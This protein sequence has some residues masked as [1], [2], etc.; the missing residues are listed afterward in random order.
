M[1][2][3]WV[4]LA[5]SLTWLASTL[6]ALHPPKWGLASIPSFFAGWVVSELPGFNLLAQ[7]VATALLAWGGA[8]HHWPGWLGLAFG[9]ASWVG[10]AVLELSSVRSWRH[11]EDALESMGMPP[12]GK[13]SVP[14]L[15]AR[16]PV[17][18]IPRSVERVRN[19]D[20]WGDGIPPHR[21]DIYRPRPASLAASSASSSPGT[22]AGSGPG[23]APVLL[24][25]HGGGWVI[26]DKR[27]QGR[28][29][30]HHLARSGWVCVTANYRL[31]PRATWP[32]L[33]IDCKRALSWVKE[34]I[35][36]YGGDP[37]RIIVSGGSAGGHLAAWV[38]LTAGD[39]EFQPGFEAV[40]T[41]VAGCLPFYGVYDFTNDG[42]AFDRRFTAFLERAVFKS[43]LADNR[44]AFEGASPYWRAHPG[45]PPFLAIAGRNDTLVPVAEPRRF[46]EKLRATSTNPVGYVELPFTQHAFEIFPTVRC[47]YAIRTVNRFLQF[48]ESSNVATHD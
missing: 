8:L 32:D 7:V 5:L 39:P 25:I 35:A 3:S 47:S 31:S 28:P 1:T 6:N 23:G 20:Y 9:V 40:D 17:T 29:M 21:L 14:F 15:E 41:T 19:V 11:I 45:A 30:M 10:L 36:S 38:A 4:F 33:G 16:I 44:A 48:V 46:V 13:P 37:S 12:A 43:K 27:E 26:G 42:G 34:N 22:P 24:Y 2:L 18:A